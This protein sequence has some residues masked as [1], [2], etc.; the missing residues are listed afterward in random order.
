[1]RFIFVALAALLFTGCTHHKPFVE[2]STGYT[3]NQQNYSD[4]YANCAIA[5]QARAGFETRFGVAY[6][7]GHDSNVD[8]GRPFND[9]KE[10]FRDYV[11]ISKKWGGQ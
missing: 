10:P 1:M 5:F 9:R 4:Q 3:F 8:C 11:F 7:Y 2:L 6:G